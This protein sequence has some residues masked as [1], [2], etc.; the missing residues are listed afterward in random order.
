MR[1]LD[2][3]EILRVDKDVPLVMSDNVLASS[4]NLSNATESRLI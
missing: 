4:I 2:V 1:I 3:S